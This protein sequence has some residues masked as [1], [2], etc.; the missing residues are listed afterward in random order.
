MKPLHSIAGIILA[1]GASE[2]MD[3]PKPLLAFPDG[4][5][6]LA[7]QVQLLRSAG[8]SEVAVVIGAHAQKIRSSHQGIE[9][10]WLTNEHWEVGQFSSIQVGISRILQ[11]EATGAIILPVD[12]AGVSHSTVQAIIDTALRNPHLEAIVPEY[13]EEGGHP[14]YVSKGFGETLARIDPRDE[15][16]RLDI[17][18]RGAKY[19]MRLPV[20]DPHI[21]SNINT[22]Q[23]WE[24]QISST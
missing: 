20:N 23:D 7:S 16:A 10:T 19:V 3:S 4:T 24:D 11:T 13:G 22:A 15:A 5:T 14:V 6:L 2:R 9:V 8:C 21:T 1:A 12:T 18:L 17:Q